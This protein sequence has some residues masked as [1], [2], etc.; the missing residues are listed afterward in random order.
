MSSSDHFDDPVLK[1]ALKR[2]CG[3]EQA[4]ERLRQ[5]LM[6]QMGVSPQAAPDPAPPPA[7]KLP[8]TTRPHAR[9]NPW[10]S[11]F[12]PRLVTALA[13]VLVLAIGAGLLVYRNMPT[14]SRI[15][16]EAMLAMIR[17][18]D[19]CAVAE[20]HRGADVPEDL[21]GAGAA[22]G[23]TLG[24]TVLAANLVEDGWT[25]RGGSICPVAGKPSAHFLF[26]RGTQR[27]SVFS[28]PAGAGFEVRPGA[29]CNACVEGHM[30]AGFVDQ[31][32]VYCM[33]GFC[34][35]KNVTLEEVTALM[36]K[37]RSELINAVVAL[38]L[39]DVEG[40]GHAH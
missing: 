21:R 34:K 38:Q 9:N 35:T 23:R 5:S 39:D 28:L 27:L 17:T 31:G 15:A 37:H 18:H 10:L 33:V 14:K 40:D 3:K 19:A 25:L 30:V 1:A 24:Q 26:Q 7:L 8:Q 2:A 11:L 12:Q 13:A 4:P 16:H 20:G 32:R 29:V 22:L 36:N 6:Q